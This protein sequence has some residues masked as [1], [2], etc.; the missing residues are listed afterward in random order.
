VAIGTVAVAAASADAGSPI[1]LIRAHG[2][3]SR[4]LAEGPVPA[5]FFEK[6]S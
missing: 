3:I 4:K 2:M 6:I 5:F 1:T